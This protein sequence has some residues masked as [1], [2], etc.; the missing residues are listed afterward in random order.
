MMANLTL[1]VES[2]SSAF[3]FE[4][5]FPFSTPF[6][7]FLHILPV[8]IHQ[9]SALYKKNGIEMELNLIFKWNPAHYKTF[10]FE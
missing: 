7:S 4:I 5:T 8:L 9:N 1:G 6:L 10:K 3:S 2:G